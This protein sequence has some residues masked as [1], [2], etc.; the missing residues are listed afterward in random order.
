[1]CPCFSQKVKMS[2]FFQKSFHHF[3]KQNIIVFYWFTDVLFISN[4]PYMLMTFGILLFPLLSVVWLTIFYRILNRMLLHLHYDMIYMV[5]CLTT[6]K[7]SSWLFVNS[8]SLEAVLCKK[9][10]IFIFCRVHTLSRHP[11]W[12]WH[13]AYN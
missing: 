13:E 6:F 4:I 5:N 3:A 1:M 10:L 12:S 7:G 11:F 2:S 8:S 9:M